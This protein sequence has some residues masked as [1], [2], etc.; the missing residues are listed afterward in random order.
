MSP[1]KITQNHLTASQQS[2]SDSD[3]IAQAKYRLYKILSQQPKDYEA[4]HLLRQISQNYPSR[5]LTDNQKFLAT[6]E[7]EYH[8][9]YK[10]AVNLAALGWRYC[11]GLDGEF[12]D[13]SL[14]AIL[15][16][17]PRESHPK[18]VLPKSP[19]T[20]S[21]YLEKILSI[22]DIQTRW[23]YVNELIATPNEQLLVDDFADIGDFELADALRKNLGGGKLNILILGAGCVGLALANALKTSLGEL[24]NIL[25]IENRV[26]AKHIKKPYTRNWL[27]NL[28]NFIYE[29][30]FDPQ[31]VTILREFGNG[32]YMGVPLNILETLLFISNRAK[33]VHF[34]FDDKYKLS[35]INETDTDMVIDATGGKLNLIDADEF[36]DGSFVV[37]LPG[38]RRLGS[39]YRGFGITNTN[40]LPP[41]RLKMKKQGTFFYPSF[42]DKQLKSAIFKLTNVPLELYEPLL[43]QVKKNNSDSLIY[44]WPGKLRTELNSLLIL[45][46]LSPADYQHIGQ[47]VCQKTNFHSFMTRYAKDLQLDQRILDFFEKI[48]AGD[49]QRGSQIEP[50]FLYEPYLR[51]SGEKLPRIFGRPVFRIGD[52]VFNGHPKVGNGL[53]SHLGIVGKLHDVILAFS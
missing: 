9:I 14:P 45:I 2:F 52:S 13:P 11:L 10:Q 4:R 16:Q 12:I 46:N 15:P 43:I 19:H 49:R 34:Y 25:M 33:G 21:E 42:V 3:S 26:Q 39:K 38:C 44:I 18:I 35:L 28:S 17:K 24:V 31:V 32:H 53:G 5:F 6:L 51:Q 50:P 20:A 27:T 40:D 48:L 8:V 7:Q 29:D 1:E 47:C 37:K 23:G 30:F 22:S 36:D 41:M